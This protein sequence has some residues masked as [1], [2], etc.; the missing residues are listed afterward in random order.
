MIRW[1]LSSAVLLGLLGGPMAMAE[2]AH[3]NHFASVL[4]DGDKIGQVHYSVKFDAEGELEELQTKASVSVF[5][6]KLYDFTQHL[7]E[8]WRDEELQSLWGHT[9]EDGTD[10][11]V[12]VTRTA[13]GYS[14][15]LN[16]KPLTLPA[17]AFPISLWHYAVTRQTLLF[18]FV[19]LRLLRVE[20]AQ[21]DDSV[22]HAGRTI[23]A[24]RFDFTGDWE[25]SVW[26]DAEEIFVKAEYKDDDRLV[27]VVMDP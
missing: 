21:H 14:A 12:S 25:G 17:N 13:N 16:E 5:G 8:R 10:S 2:D 19:D 4:L 11:H 3:R 23:R 22:T 27:T 20:V 9:K 1:I 7:H 18:D 15:Q 6:I 24:K 26:F